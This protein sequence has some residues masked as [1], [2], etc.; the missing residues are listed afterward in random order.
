MPT[1][2]RSKLLI[3]SSFAAIYIIWGSTYLFAAFAMDE[4]PPFLMAGSRYG[5]AGLLLLTLTFLVKKNES[6]TQKQLLNTLFA[7]V[8]MLGVGGGF[9]FWGLQFID[10][11][12]T[13]LV[14]SGQPLLILFMMWGI[15]GKKPHK[16]AYLGILL[17]MLGMYL[18]VSQ[19]T[20]VANPNQWMG[21]LA[22]FVSMLSWG[23][24]SLFLG[25]A[26]MP[27]S[28][29]MSSSIQMIVGGSFLLIVSGFLENP[30][31]VNWLEL[32]NVTYLA[33]IYLIIFGSIIAFSAFN[34]LLSEVSPDKVSTSTYVNPIVAMFLGWSFRDEIITSQSMLAAAIMLTGVF[35][36]NA[37]PEYSQ[38][39]LQRI[40]MVGRR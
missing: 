39:L 10:S 15:Q 18:L 22:I 33:M 1:F 32:Q 23:Y 8:L 30:M 11:G 4:L 25:T 3:I 7:G 34:F 14:I 21:V 16:Q 24:G 19:K 38:K 12:F 31:Q 20:L 26:D 28:K 13:A 40:R 27:K 5:T 2:N 9:V 6:M 35:F 36:I 37:K 29:M 17:G